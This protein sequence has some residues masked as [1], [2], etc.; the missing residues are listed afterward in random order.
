MWTPSL[1]APAS[2]YAYCRRPFIETWPRRGVL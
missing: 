2:Y 1:D